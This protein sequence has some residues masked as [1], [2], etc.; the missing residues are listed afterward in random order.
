M[1]FKALLY[2]VLIVVLNIVLFFSEGCG[3]NDLRHIRLSSPSD[4]AVE[5]I[6]GGVS[7]AGHDGGVMN[8]EDDLSETVNVYNIKNPSDPLHPEP[9]TG[10]IVNGVIVSSPCVPNTTETGFSKF[11]V[12]QKN[13]GE[14]SG[15]LVIAP[16]ELIV[17]SIA[18][19]DIVDINGYYTEIHGENDTCSSPVIM[20][21]YIST[22]G[23][24]VLP[25]PEKVE[26]PHEI[27]SG[28]H[29]L[30]EYEGVYI[31]VGGVAA[32]TSTGVNS[33]WKA[34]GGLTIGNMFFSRPVSAGE[35]FESIAGIL[36]IDSGEYVLEPRFADDIRVLGHRFYD[37]DGS[38]PDAHP[39]DAG[40][41]IPD[42]GVS[43]GGADGGIEIDAGVDCSTRAGHAVISQ[44]AS[45]GP[46]GGN[47]E[48]LE[49][50]NPGVEPINISGWK[51]EAAS[52]AISDGGSVSVQWNVRAEIGDSAASPVL[53]PGGY[54]LFANKNSQG[55]YSGAY[56]DAKYTSGITDQSGVRI[57]DADGNVVDSAG[58]SSHVSE[59]KEV[60]NPCPASG[61]CSASVVRKAHAASNAE[62][63]KEGGADSESGNGHDTDD[64]FSDFVI[65]ENRMPRFSGSIPAVN[66]CQKGDVIF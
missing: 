39:Y 43:D 66:P 6:D 26:D 2:F 16:D 14:F 27:A 19:A 52:I 44:F 42:S 21:K 31:E 50:F 12:E 59:G 48:F 18:V 13:G 40:Q 58:F 1:K 62:S 60:K 57:V 33:R 17:D 55:G 35:A 56:Y 29:L 28:G 45:R 37:L 38:F 5:G 9:G 10:I 36:H 24:G 22:A 32:I 61:S 41:L 4:G 7:D 30:H 65:I 49:L 54:F 20:A 34:T 47:D 46:S 3:V 64:N 11:F 63:M 51:L 23:K 25:S 8:N 53:E 15:I